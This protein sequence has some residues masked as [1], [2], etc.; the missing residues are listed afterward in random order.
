VI[1]AVMRGGRDRTR[2]CDL[3]RVKENVQF[4]RLYRFSQIPNI[5]NNLGNVLFAQEATQ[6]LA[7]DGVSDTVLAQRRWGEPL[8]VR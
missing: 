4:Q 8:A 1:D 3:L 2:T 5:Y 7:T 6:V